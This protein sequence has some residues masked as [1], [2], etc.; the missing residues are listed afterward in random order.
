[1]PT[2][3]SFSKGE[4]FGQKGL[5]S[6]VNTAHLIL[7]CQLSIVSIFEMLQQRYLIIGNPLHMSAMML[8]MT[9]PFSFIH[10]LYTA[11]A[12]TWLMM[13]MMMMMMHGDHNEEEEDEVSKASNV[14]AVHKDDEQED[15]WVSHLPSLQHKKVP[16]KFVS[17]TAFQPF[18]LIFSARLG[19]CPPALFTIKSI[20]P[21]VSRAVLTRLLTLKW[22]KE[23][24][25]NWLFTCTI[26]KD[27]S[28]PCTDEYHQYLYS[29]YTYGHSRDSTFAWSVL[30]P[31]LSI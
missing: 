10:W 16:V 15:G 3:G 13:T 27:F 14:A 23:E 4:V 30:F 1:M 31:R 18:R 26:S 2:V 11:L 7:S 8:I 12:T 25:F 28:H 20:W 6:G 21:N 24:R 5:Y 22:N 17:I 29:S 19:N 9:P